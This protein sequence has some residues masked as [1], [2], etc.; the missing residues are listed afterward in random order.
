MLFTESRVEVK[1]VGQELVLTL[2]Y[3]VTILA[4]CGYCIKAIS[5]NSAVLLSFYS[6][7][8]FRCH[9]L[10]LIISILCG[11]PGPLCTADTKP[12]GVY[13]GCL[14]HLRLLVG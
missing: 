8:P 10:S 2:N 7:T 4:Q 14:S 5:S 12:S 13:R 3:E 6:N 11:P 9:S 1:C